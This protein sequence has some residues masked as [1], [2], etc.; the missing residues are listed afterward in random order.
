V[1]F[2]FVA[3]L[4]VLLGVPS[5]AGTIVLGTASSFGMLGGTVS[6][7]G[8]SIVIGNVGA[9]TTVTGFPPGTAT[10]TVYPAPSNP[11]V[12]AAY[13]DFESAFNTADSNALT[14]ATQTVADLTTSRTFVGNNVYQFSATDVTSSAGIILNFDAQ[15]NSSETFILRIAGNMTINGPIAFT[16]SN[17]ALAT[18]I[19]WIIGDAATLDP[20]GLPIT[21]DGNV[22]AGTSFTMSANTGGSGVLAGTVN[23]CVFAETA[24]TLAGQTQINGCSSNASS[25]PEPAYIGW[26]GLGALVAV[27]VRKSFSL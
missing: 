14:P 4:A 18:N 13:S 19:Y 24:N 10:G 11:T 25:V 3:A 26:L 15:A 5:F 9:T 21:W 1:H 17:G 2:R 12:A 23:G 6:N 8:T 22:L 20:S 27:G 7:T 16:L